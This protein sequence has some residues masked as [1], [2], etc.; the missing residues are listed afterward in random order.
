MLEIFFPIRIENKFILSNKVLNIYFSQQAIYANLVL[1][2]SY[3]RIILKTIKLDVDFEDKGNYESFLVNNLEK[4]FRSLVFD[5]VRL[6][7]TSNNAVFKILETPFNDIEKIKMIIP[8]ELEPNLPFSLSDCSIDAVLITDNISNNKVL[9]AIVKQETIF[10]Y[11]D[12]FKQAGINLNAITID[13]IEVVSD[14]LNKKWDKDHLLMICD[15]FSTVLLAYQ[16]DLLVGIRSFDKSLFNNEENLIKFLDKNETEKI[17]NDNNDSVNKNEIQDKEK[18][19]N[20]EKNEIEEK[21]EIENN[22]DKDSIPIE[23]NISEIIKIFCKQSSISISNSN[24]YVIGA[25]EQ[26]EIF[27]FIEKNTGLKV[28]HYELSEKRGLI[29]IKQSDDN[30]SKFFQDPKSDIMLIGSI[31]YERAS[32]FNLAHEE[33]LEYKKNILWKQVLAIII[34]TFVIFIILISVN[35]FIINKQNNYYNDIERESISVLKKEFQLQSK[36]TVSFDK[37][38]KEAEKSVSEL[39]L[40]LPSVATEERYQFVKIIDKI[41]SF[42]S[43]D[44]KGLLINEIKWKSGSSNYDTVSI[45]G[46]VADFTSLRV[47]EDNLKKSSIFISIPQ[48]QDLRFSFGSLLVLKTKSEFYGSN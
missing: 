24:I 46:V 44:I 10:F 48:Q 29:N 7:I 21:K 38:I 34:S 22:N 36:H 15:S 37:A 1:V 39:I 20:I 47:L 13:L 5:Y 9:A 14:H 43:P 42:L 12:I 33:D 40:N 45:S 4:H 26:I 31:L 6:I 25:D 16:K 30:S 32:F 2:N 19:K 28:E 27:S 17:K 11:K 18:V 3:E 35:I 41:S 23:K 8:F